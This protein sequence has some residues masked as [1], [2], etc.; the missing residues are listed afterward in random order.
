[1][2]DNLER[3]DI[4]LQILKVAGEVGLSGEELARVKKI[5]F[6]HLDAERIDTTNEVERAEDEYLERPQFNRLNPQSEASQIS[7][8]ADFVRVVSTGQR[9]GWSKLPGR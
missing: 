7:E 2:T 9:T 8:S 4:A 3:F 1:M 6:A 5:A